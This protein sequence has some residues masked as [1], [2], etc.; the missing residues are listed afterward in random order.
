MEDAL[1][2]ALNMNLDYSMPNEPVDKITKS[3]YIFG[4]KAHVNRTVCETVMGILVI[5]RII[6]STKIF[7]QNPWS[8]LLD[9]PP[10]QCSL[11]RLQP[12]LL[13]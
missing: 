9:T 8:R 6:R 5:H 13:S 4:L 1:A 3:S 7:L 12:R 2:K 10:V 11:H